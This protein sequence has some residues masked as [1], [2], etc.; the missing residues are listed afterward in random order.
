MTCTYLASFELFS[1]YQTL[2]GSRGEEE[3]MWDG[4]V[5]EVDATLEVMRVLLMDL[6]RKLFWLMLQAPLTPS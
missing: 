4:L 5:V 6:Q 1:S 3:A 2:V